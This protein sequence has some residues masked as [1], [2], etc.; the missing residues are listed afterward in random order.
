MFG[1]RTFQYLFI[2]QQLVKWVECSSMAQETEVQSLVESYQRLKK[3]HLICLCLTLGIIRYISRVKW[4]NPGKGVAISPTLGVAAI[5]KGTF[6][7]PLTMVANF[8]LYKIWIIKSKDDL[9]FL[10]EHCWCFKP[11]WLS[12]GP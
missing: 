6:G 1:L 12:S 3:W 9:L 11:I 2:Y 4:S 7:L 8:T 10:Y 5:G